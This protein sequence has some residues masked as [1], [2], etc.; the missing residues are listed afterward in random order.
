MYRPY[1]R[2]GEPIRQRRTYTSLTPPVSSLPMVNAPYFITMVQSSMTT[3]RHGSLTRSP[4]SSRPDLIAIESSPTS[5]W[6]RRT[7]T[8]V[9]DSGSKP[10]LFGPWLTTSTSSTS[11]FVHSTGWITHI[12]D[13][14]IRTPCSH[15]LRQRLSSIMFGRRCQPGPVRRSWGGTPRRTIST[16]SCQCASCGTIPSC[17]PYSSRPHHDHQCSLSALPSRVPPPVI[18]TFC[19]SLAYTSGE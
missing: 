7:T 15:T 1:Q 13:R 5:K 3:F 11:T 6:Q 14:R 10:S 9:H 19:A 17:Q 8:S 12:G 18:A 16:R 4:S 2:F